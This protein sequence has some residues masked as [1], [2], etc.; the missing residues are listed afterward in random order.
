MKHLIVVS[1]L[2]FY[3]SS[4]CFAMDGTDKALLIMRLVDWGQTRDIAT[5]KCKSPY[6]SDYDG[7]KYVFHEKNSFLGKHPSIKKVDTYFVSTIALDFFVSHLAV[8]NKFIN[9]FK[10]YYQQY[11]I[12]DTYRCIAGNYNLGIRIKF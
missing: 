2:L 4:S 12:C 1:I 8:K 7:S 5:R 11:A 9:K 6:I 10:T 3:F